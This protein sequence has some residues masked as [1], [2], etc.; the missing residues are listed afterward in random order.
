KHEG[1]TP[2]MRIQTGRDGN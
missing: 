2:N 1:E